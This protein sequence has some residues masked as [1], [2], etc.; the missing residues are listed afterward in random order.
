[1]SVRR[2]QTHELEAIAEDFLLTGGSTTRSFCTCGWKSRGAT[3]P[4]VALGLWR[5]HLVLAGRG[6]TRK[7]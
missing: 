7:Q 3:S 2:P 6:L 1:M 4:G 5:R